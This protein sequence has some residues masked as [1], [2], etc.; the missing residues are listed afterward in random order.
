MTDY[1]GY[2]EITPSSEELKEFLSEENL[3]EKDE[4]KG[5]A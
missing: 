5:D 3:Y 2:M 1:N 4:K